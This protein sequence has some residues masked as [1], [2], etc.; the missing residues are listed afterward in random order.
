MLTCMQKINF[1]THFFLKI[2]QRNNKLVILDNLGIFE[3]LK[4][5]SM[6]ICRQKI[7]FNFQVSLEILKDITTL[8]LWILWTTHTHKVIS[9]TCRK[10]SR[11][12]AGKKKQLHSPLSLEMLQKYANL[13]WVLWECLAM[14]NQNNCI[15]L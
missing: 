6:F 12:S 14:H 13:F 5:P 11:L 8:L 7:N 10:L 15:N 1:L 2:L 4:K 3:N 9:S